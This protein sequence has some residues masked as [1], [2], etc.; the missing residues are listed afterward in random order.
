VSADGK[1][2]GG[3]V[4]GRYQ[5]FA[6]AREL[7]SLVAGLSA[8]AIVFDIEPLVAPWY[9]SQAALDDGIARVIDEV[10]AVPGLRAVCFANEL[11]PAPVDAAARAGHRGVLPGLGEQA[12]AH[13]SVRAAAGTRRRSR[14]PGADRRDT[15]QPAK[16]L[17]PAL[18]PAVAHADQA[19]AARSLRRARATGDVP[20]V[21]RHHDRRRDA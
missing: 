16:F 18:P 4:T 14:R 21:M 1:L 20:E 11:G 8:H 19:A 7:P 5:S 3:G 6:D 9:G 12:H 13:G 17:V 15:R 2:W 10:A